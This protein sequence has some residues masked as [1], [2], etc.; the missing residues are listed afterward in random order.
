MFFSSSFFFFHWNIKRNVFVFK[1]MVKLSLWLWQARYGENGQGS[2]KIQVPMTVAWLAKFLV[3][4]LAFSVLPNFFF[5]AARRLKL[6][7]RYRHEVR[8]QGR[9][10][11]PLKTFGQIRYLTANILTFSFR[12]CAEQSINREIWCLHQTATRFSVLLVIESLC[13][14]SSSKPRQKF[15]ADDTFSRIES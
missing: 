12:I 11:Y 8:F 13:S 15:K 9:L 3:T 14:I 1:T 5:W 2:S 10:L 6:A 7:F 4:W